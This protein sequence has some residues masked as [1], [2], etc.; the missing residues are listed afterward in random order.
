M[1]LAICVNSI[2]IL[3]KGG[4]ESTVYFN[5]DVEQRLTDYI[6][7]ER[8]APE[9]DPDALFV[10]RNKTRIT[11]R[12]VERMVKK[13]T[14]ASVPQKKITPHKMR[15][16]YGT[17]LYQETNDIYLVA[18]VLGHNDVNTTKKH[19]AAIDDDLKRSAAGAVKWEK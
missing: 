3:R 14:Q 2:R 19:Y 5:E 7:L 6:E 17:N 13:Y 12:S 10:S 4:N 15:S 9:T 1:H 8:Q 16:T 18:D 11:V